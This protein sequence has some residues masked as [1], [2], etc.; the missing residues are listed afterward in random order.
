M[1]TIS[2]YGNTFVF[3][4]RRNDREEIRKKLAMGADDDSYDDN[5]EEED[6]GY[7]KPNIQSRLHSG[8][9]VVED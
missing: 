4:A 6:L 8:L 9:Q 2:K 5:E 7:K 1:T 3:Q